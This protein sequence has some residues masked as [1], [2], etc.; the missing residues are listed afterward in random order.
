MPEDVVLDAY[1]YY[2]GTQIEER[3]TIRD[4][5][6]MVF[7]YDFGG[8]RDSSVSCLQT[9]DISIVSDKATVTL[10]VVKIRRASS[11]IPCHVLQHDG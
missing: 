9:S 10:R 5:A 7:S 11:K 2:L 6:I 1:A 4:A 8:L 3:E